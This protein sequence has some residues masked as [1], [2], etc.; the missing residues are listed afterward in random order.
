MEKPLVNK[1]YLL[2]KYPGKG[3]W[4]YT[5]I[6]GIPATLRSRGGMVK[7]KGFV[8]DFEIKCYN[9]FPTKSKPTT[10]FF[11]VKADI[12]KKIGKQEGDYVQ[13]ILYAD[14]NPTE[15]P[16]ELMLCLLDNPIA[17]KKLLSYSDG[18]QKAFINWIYSAKTDHTKVERIAK[19][20]ENLEKGKKFAD[21]IMTTK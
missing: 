9:L 10:Y 5:L 18:E 8:D 19:T 16:V 4:T 2:E 13:I 14:N 3:G 21:K 15:I 1:K 12:R 6:S 7:V 20:L 17:H 11:P